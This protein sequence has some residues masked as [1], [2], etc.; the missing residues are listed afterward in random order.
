MLK[1]I[2]C[3]KKDYKIKLEKFI[4]LNNENN[5]N[6][7]RTVSKIIEKVRKRGD[8][9]LLSISKKLD[10]ATFKNTNE[11]LVTRKE[12]NEAEKN[13]SKGFH[14]AVEEAVDR[15]TKYQ[16]KLLPK[17]FYFKD[18]EGINLGCIWTCLSSCGLYVPGGKAF[19]PSSVLMNA[20]PAK[21][22][23]VKRIAMTTPVN[24]KKIKPEILV[25]AKA[26][27]IK[28]VYKLGGAQAIAA[29]A[30]G[31]KLIKK[32]D[33][34][35]GPGNAFV[36]EAKRQVFGYVGIDSIAGP[37]E[38]LII[39]DRYCNPKWVAIDLISQAE[40]DEEARAILITDDA[41]FLTK[42]NKNIK[43]Y[44]K[45]INRSAIANISI[46][47]NG[48]GILMKNLNEA[49]LVSN[50]IAPE[51]LQIM[52]KNKKNIL[53][54][55]TNAGAIFVGKY[56]PEALG[57]YIA[58]PSHVLPTSGNARFD[59][60]LSVLDFLKRTSYIEASKKGLYKVIK[61][62]EIIGNSEGLDAHVKSALIR[63][64][65]GS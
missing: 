6:R 37:S 44:L 30:Y 4:S 50:Y 47:N 35:V 11:L 36:A 2:K 23:G 20:I 21:I 48:L 62:I 15:I 46:K 59:S 16:K 22:A 45:K 25:A 3:T 51:H 39:A 63:F 53:K 60:G 7:A 29:L 27:G 9:A 56:S 31:T 52:S 58:G 24:N 64:S 28:E 57:D 10:K 43:E 55:I 54:K 38:V 65:K 49:Y 34:I 61:P 5:L 19:Y 26:A 1:K 8:Y 17:S 41:D 40:H 14:K 13:C 18:K 32:V 42:V 12:F 33:K